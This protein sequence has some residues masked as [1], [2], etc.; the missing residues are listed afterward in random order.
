MGKKPRDGGT[1]QGMINNALESDPDGVAFVV[2]NDGQ[3]EGLIDPSDADR[4]SGQIQMIGTLL[5]DVA[6][7]TGTHPAVVAFDVVKWAVAQWDA[8]SMQATVGDGSGPD[9]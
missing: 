7:R 3:A 6:K 4:S 5:L 8:P 1:V 9:D 2:L